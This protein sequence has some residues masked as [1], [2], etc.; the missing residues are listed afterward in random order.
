MGDL[1]KKLE[2][3]LARSK[4]LEKAL[5][6]ASQQESAVRAK[7]L[8]ATTELINGIPTIIANLGQIDGDALQA[9]VDSLK[10]EFQRRRRLG[11]E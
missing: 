4:E 3:L 6:A 1:E 2:A 5:K 9:I 8:A 10:S 7:E 11:G